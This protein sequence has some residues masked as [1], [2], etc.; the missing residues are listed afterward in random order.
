M[1]FVFLDDIKHGYVKIHRSNCK[2]YLNGNRN[3]IASNG[4]W[5]GKFPTYIEALSGAKK[6]KRHAI[7][8]CKLC[9]PKRLVN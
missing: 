2:C 1:S 6:T 4:K 3:S 9:K 5:H 8:D 7:D